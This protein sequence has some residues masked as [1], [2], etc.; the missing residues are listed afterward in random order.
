MIENTMIDNIETNNLQIKTF[1]LYTQNIR[2]LDWLLLGIRPTHTY[3]I[4]FRKIKG[5]KDIQRTQT[6]DTYYKPNKFLKSKLYQDLKHNIS[7][8]VE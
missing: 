5:N 6:I 4:M 1:F 3:K 7:K 2:W 8:E